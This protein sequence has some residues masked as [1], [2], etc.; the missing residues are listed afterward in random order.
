MLEDGTM[1]LSPWEWEIESH[2]MTLARDDDLSCAVTGVDQDGV[3]FV[4]TEEYIGK[5]ISLIA[6]GLGCPVEDFAESTAEFVRGLDKIG[7]ERSAAMQAALDNLAEAIGFTPE[8]PVL[9]E[10]FTLSDVH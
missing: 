2:Y 10:T 7:T 6:T 4:P 3:R 1:T 9:I 5:A 8:A